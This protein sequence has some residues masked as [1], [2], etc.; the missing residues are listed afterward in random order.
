MITS[1]DHDLTASCLLFEVALQTQGCIGRFEHLV[2]DTAMWRVA[3]GAAILSGFVA[4]HKMIVLGA[5]AFRASLTRAVQGHASSSNRVAMR[6][7]TIRAGHVAVV[8][9]MSIGK[10]EG[11]TGIEVALETG[12]GE[13][14]PGS[15]CMRHPATLGM[16]TSGSMTRLA[17][18]MKIFISL[19][20]DLRMGGPLKIGH[21]FFMTRGAFAHSHKFRTGHLWGR[22]DRM[23]YRNAG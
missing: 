11:G 19:G 5:M 3:G 15:R 7:M 20:H 13:I 21:Q 16:Q 12:L 2:I 22:Q 18:Q 6:I 1:S 4:E 23:G 10:I 14:F 8:H 9:I 17:P